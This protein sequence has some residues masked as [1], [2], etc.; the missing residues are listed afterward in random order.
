VAA[1]TIV[2]L[3]FAVT[4]PTLAGYVL[5]GMVRSGR[6]LS[7]R[8]AKAP[9]PEPPAALEARLRRLRAELEAMEARPGM[10]AKGH[11]L[12]AVRGAYLDTLREAC[13][14]LEVPPPP[15]GDRARQADI[16]R[17]EAG[18]RARGIDVR[19]PAGR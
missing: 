3:V 6:G 10:T 14:R 19:E 8:R 13:T 5:I 2:F 17:A 9:P 4:L 16:Y 18:L 11:H 1:T 7:E 12:A 15:G